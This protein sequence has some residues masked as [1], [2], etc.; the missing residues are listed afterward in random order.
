[1][2]RSSHWYDADLTH[3]RA[4]GLAQGEHLGGHGILWLQLARVAP[5]E[6]AAIHHPPPDHRAALAPV[7]QVFKH[8][9]AIV[10]QEPLGGSVDLALHVPTAR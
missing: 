5:I 1:M 4:R 6:H 10:V 9:A 3:L 8:V 2:K 7:A